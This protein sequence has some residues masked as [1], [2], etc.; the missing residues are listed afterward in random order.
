MNHLNQPSLFLRGQTCGFRFREASISKFLGHLKV[1]DLRVGKPSSPDDLKFVEKSIRKNQRHL[2]FFWGGG[3]VNFRVEYRKYPL[4]KRK[5]VYFPWQFSITISSDCWP[6]VGKNGMCLEAK[7]VGVGF[8]AE[9]KKQA[10]PT[11]PSKNFGDMS[12]GLETT[13]FKAW[14]VSPW[15]EIRL[16][17]DTRNRYP[18]PNFLSTRHTPQSRKDTVL[19]WAPQL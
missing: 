16:C 5:V 17:M 1:S 15:Q 2:H 14:K 8:T 7:N 9:K 6:Y 11:S 12:S 13:C 4:R 10:S 18:K 3:H 19:T